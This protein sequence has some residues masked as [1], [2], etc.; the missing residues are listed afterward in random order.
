MKIVFVLIKIEKNGRLFENQSGLKTVREK[1]EL[2]KVIWKLES[3][4]FI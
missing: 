4:E 2:S 1:I 3:Q